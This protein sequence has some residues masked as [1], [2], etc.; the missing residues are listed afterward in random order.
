CAR[1]MDGSS[2]IDYW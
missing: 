2:S 1:H